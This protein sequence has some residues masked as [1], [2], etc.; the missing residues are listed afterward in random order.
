[1]TR[2]GDFLI[3]T[4]VP[5]ATFLQVFLHYYPSPLDREPRLGSFL[6]KPI[7]SH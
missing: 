2:A 3:T 7:D 6:G 4:R 1:M 5:G